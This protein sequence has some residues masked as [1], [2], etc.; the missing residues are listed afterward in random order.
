MTTTVWLAI[1]DPS[2]QLEH[3]MKWEGH[4]TKESAEKEFLLIRQ[5]IRSD[6]AKYPNTYIYE[7]DVPL[8]G[9]PEEEFDLS[10]LD[11]TLDFVHNEHKVTEEDELAEVAKLAEKSR[12]KK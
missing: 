8:Y 11:R 4:L 3:H 7:G 10:Y 2:T 5:M 6:N 12:N 9:Y 1:E